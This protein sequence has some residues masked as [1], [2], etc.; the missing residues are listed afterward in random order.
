MHHAF[1]GLGVFSY[2]SIVRCIAVWILI[3][4]CSVVVFSS[5]L[6]CVLMI[7][8]LAWL[9]MSCLC[10]VYLPSESIF[11]VSCRRRGIGFWKIVYV[12]RWSV[13]GGEM[14]SAVIAVWVSVVRVTSMRL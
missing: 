4:C 11:W 9:S 7:S 14:V 12:G 3:R 5:V 13:I 2:R 6:S 8:E 1:R 10:L